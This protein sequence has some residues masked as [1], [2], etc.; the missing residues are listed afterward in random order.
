MRLPVDTSVVHFVSAGPAEPSIDFDTKQQKTDAKGVAINQVHLF[1]VGDGGTRE[2]ITVEKERSSTFEVTR[3]FGTDF[4]TH[5]NQCE[6]QRAPRVTRCAEK[7]QVRNAS[8]ENHRENHPRWKCVCDP[9]ALR[10]I[11]Q[12]LRSSTLNSTAKPPVQWSTHQRS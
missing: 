6:N 3:R 7:A 8:G 1:V 11:A 5:E 10:V 12:P 9:L 2:V 4:G